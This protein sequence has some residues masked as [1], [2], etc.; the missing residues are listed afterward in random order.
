M[1]LECQTLHREVTD[2]ECAKA[3]RQLP[4]HF[5]EGCEW[6][7]K[8]IYTPSKYTVYLSKKLKAVVAE[9]SKKLGIKPRVY[10]AKILAEKLI[11][12]D[13]ENPTP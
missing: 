13:T 11:P 6:L 1:K 9:E 2:I 8:T 5:C 12:A 3:Q 7:S 10:I 4:R